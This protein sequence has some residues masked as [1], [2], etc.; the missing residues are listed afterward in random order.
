MLARELVTKS[1]QVFCELSSS[2]SPRRMKYIDRERSKW[3][4][5]EYLH[6]STSGDVDRLNGSNQT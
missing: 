5:L 1:S 6:A 4:L 2:D 3:G